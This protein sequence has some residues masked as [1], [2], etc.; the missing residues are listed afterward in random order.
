MTITTVTWTIYPG[1]DIPSDEQNCVSASSTVASNTQVVGPNVTNP[2]RE[3]TY[4]VPYTNGCSGTE[5]TGSTVGK[6]DLQGSNPPIS[7]VSTDPAVPF[8]MAPG[9]SQEL[10]VTFHAL[11]GNYYDGPLAIEVIVD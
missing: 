2:N 6:V 3:F 9:A 4:S 5:S 10:A 7:I 1:P 11:E 8:G